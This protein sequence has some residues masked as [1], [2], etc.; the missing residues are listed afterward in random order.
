[1][2]CVMCEHS[3]GSDGIVV[4]GIEKSYRVCKK[5]LKYHKHEFE[6][7]F[8]ENIS[9]KGKTTLTRKYIQEKIDEKLNHYL[10]EVWNEKKVL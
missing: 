5:C 8:D 9:E 1:M 6:I 4:F 10:W 2:K 7:E 3:S